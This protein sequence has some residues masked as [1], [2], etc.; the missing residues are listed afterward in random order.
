MA[1]LQSVSECHTNKG[2]SPILPVVTLKFVSMTPSLESSEKKR[3]D[4]Q[5][6]IKYIPYGGNLVKVGFV[7]TAFSLLKDLFRKKKSN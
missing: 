5:S 4:R 7:N 3:S 1:I 6:T 2:L